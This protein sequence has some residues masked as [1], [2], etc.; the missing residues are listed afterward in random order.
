[1]YNISINDYF[2][3]SIILAELECSTHDQRY[4]SRIL[5]NTVKR[6]RICIEGC[7]RGGSRKFSW[8]GGV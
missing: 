8:G 1:M 2:I 3:L 7:K 4:S 5:S 6:T